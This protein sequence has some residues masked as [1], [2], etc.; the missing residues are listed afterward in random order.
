LGGTGLAIVVA[1]CSAFLGPGFDGDFPSSSPIAAYATGRAT[2]AIKGGETIQLD[3]V[4]KGSGVDSAFGS[5]VRWTGA[6]GWHLRVTGA[7]GDETFGSGNGYLT[8]DRIADGQHWTT[9]YDDSRCIVDVEVVDAKAI[10]GS[11]TCK[12]VKWYD[13]LDLPFSAEEPQVLDQPKFDAEVT[14]EAVP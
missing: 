4:A 11:A 14:F 3:Q 9:G 8:F 10:R 1:G 5:D 12:G 6:S 2:I 13:A 7:G